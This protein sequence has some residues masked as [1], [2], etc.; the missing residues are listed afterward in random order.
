MNIQENACCLNCFKQILY[1]FRVISNEFL[2]LYSEYT[3]TSNVDARVQSVWS[4]WVLLKIMVH[5][6]FTAFCR[7]STEEEEEE[8]S[9]CSWT[10]IT[11]LYEL[12]SSS[13]AG[14][15]NSKDRVFST[16]YICLLFHYCSVLQD[17][18]W[19]SFNPSFMYIHKCLSVWC[20]CL[21]T[22]Q[23]KLLV[24]CSQ[25]SQWLSGNSHHTKYSGW[26]DSRTS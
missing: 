21:K 11:Q 5:F 23:I 7:G 1:Y 10:K 3:Y 14:S 9:E 6:Y 19:E 16:S 26:R 4:F 22:T 13:S 17:K 12:A 18:N 25:R 24:C 15:S 2:I 8:E 20:V